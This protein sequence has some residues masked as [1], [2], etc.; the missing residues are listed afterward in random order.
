[1]DIFFKRTFQRDIRFRK[2]SNSFLKKFSFRFF[3][4]FSKNEN[5]NILRYTNH[6]YIP[7]L[8]D[9]KETLQFIG[10]EFQLMFRSNLLTRTWAPLIEDSR[11]CTKL[12]ELF[13]GETVRIFHSIFARISTV[14]INYSF[15]FSFSIYLF[16]TWS[17]FLK[18]KKKE[19]KPRKNRLKFLRNL[20]IYISLLS[21]EFN[22][23]S[24]RKKYRSEEDCPLLF[25]CII[26]Y[27]FFHYPYSSV[28]SN[29]ESL[30][31]IK[32]ILFLF[33]QSIPMFCIRT[34][35]KSVS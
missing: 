30:R 4:F 9:Y 34:P 10:L 15:L 20:L 11:T 7:A 19:K 12:H 8:S 28:V 22:I 18:K 2:I 23:A 3:F 1:M 33:L 32:R 5:T 13:E 25:V 31:I 35:G 14:N 21:S 24:R 29:K 17:K 6:S 26:N 27:S 16:A